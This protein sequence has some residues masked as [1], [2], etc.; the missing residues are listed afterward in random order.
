M[1][2]KRAGNRVPFLAGASQPLKEPSSSR[3][4][5]DQPE[6]K[7]E[8]GVVSLELREGIANALEARSTYSSLCVLGT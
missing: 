2:F 1:L 7:E 4:R 5:N 6:A 3:C 8:I